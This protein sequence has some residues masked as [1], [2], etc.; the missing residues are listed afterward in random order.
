MDL[1]SLGIDLAIVVAIGAIAEWI[2]KQDVTQ[3]FKRFYVLIP[4]VLSILSAVG[5]SISS[6]DYS[7]ILL[8]TIKYF[9]IASF[10]YSFIKKTLINK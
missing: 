9:G 3:K 6:G 7:T 2:K 4:L 8:D 10:G 1:S 5:L